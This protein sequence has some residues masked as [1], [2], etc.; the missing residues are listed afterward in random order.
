[1]KQINSIN[2]IDASRPFEE[3]LLD[4]LLAVQATMNDG[5][6]A[7][8]SH[9]RSRQVMVASGVAASVLVVGALAIVGVRTFNPGSVTK[10][11]AQDPA[12]AILTSFEVK[13]ISAKSSAA[14][15]SGTAEVTQ[16]SAQNGVP[17]AGYDTAVTFSGQNI[18][19]KI[20]AV[21]EPSGSAKS[22]TTDD[23]FVGGQFYIYTPG[24]GDVL[25]WL[26]DTN[27]GADA[28]SMQFPDPRTLYGA[29]NPAAQ[30]TVDGTTTM[31]GEAVTHLVAAD[32]SAIDS[33]A[34]G[35]LA[36]D[37]TLTSFEIWIDANDVAQQMA[38]STSQTNQ[39]CQLGP[40]SEYGTKTAT[41]KSLKNAKRCGLMT[42]TSNVTVTFANLG[43]P[44]SVA[45]PQGAV[46]Y[47]GEG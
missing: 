36:V 19:E 21:P 10:T 27:S 13:K 28:A 37:A 32:P 31:N 47:S 5:A 43:V 9:R 22:F 15:S 3:R 33:S 4:E 17:Q 12:H 24:P 14:A 35:N 6:R 20:T 18:D 16:T 44:Q 30:F 38:L 46:N 40:L 23:R 7:S 8:R 39:A 29:I 41:F 42:T 2:V 11:T 45:V 26:H 1:V 25:E 34:L